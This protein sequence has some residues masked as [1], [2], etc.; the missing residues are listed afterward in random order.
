VERRRTIILCRSVFSGL[1]NAI[2]WIYRLSGYS[3]SLL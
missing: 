1:K 3:F 2:N